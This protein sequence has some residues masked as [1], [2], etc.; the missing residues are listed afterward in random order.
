MRKPRC[1]KSDRSRYL[2]TISQAVRFSFVVVVMAISS[3]FLILPGGGPRGLMREPATQ[4]FN[5]SPP[6]IRKLPLQPNWLKRYWLRGASV[7]RNTGLP[8]IASP[9]A[10]GRFF[11]KYFPI[12]VRAGCRLKASPSPVRREDRGDL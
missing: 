4:Q 8:V 3:L 12:I 7:L 9:L 2:L 11:K 10:M 5:T 6:R 1:L